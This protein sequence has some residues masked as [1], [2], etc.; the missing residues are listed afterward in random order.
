[1]TTPPYEVWPAVGPIE[2]YWW[3]ETAQEIAEQ[4]DEQGL[5]PTQV[6]AWTPKGRLRL[7]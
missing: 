4:M 1:M 2:S 6:H 5:G 3:L 7:R